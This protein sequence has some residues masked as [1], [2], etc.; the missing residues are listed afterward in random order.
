MR[1]TQKQVPSPLNTQTQTSRGHHRTQET[2]TK[3][4]CH[5]QNLAI[6]YNNLKVPTQQKHKKRPLNQLYKEI[7]VLKEE[8]N[9]SLKEIQENT[10][11]QLAE[12]N[13]YLKESQEKTNKQVNKENTN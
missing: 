2:T 10:N 13:K 12:I 11:Q 9:K 5:H 1:Q 6:L 7:E 4:P 3:K 8:M